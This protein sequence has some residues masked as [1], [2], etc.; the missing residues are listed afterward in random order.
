[1]EYQSCRKSGLWRFYRIYKGSRWRA[2]LQKSFRTQHPSCDRGERY[3]RGRNAPLR[4]VFKQV[5]LF[6]ACEISKRTVPILPH[7]K[8]VKVQ[9]NI[10]QQIAT[11][12]CSIGLVDPCGHS[13]SRHCCWDI[14]T[15]LPDLHLSQTTNQWDVS[16]TRLP[17]ICQSANN[18]VLRFVF[19]QLIFFKEYLK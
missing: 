19:D 18:R 16:E 1:M 2:K 13:N 9:L 15:Q 12:R 7:R 11:G 3:R 6:Y 17:Q 14:A 8:I 10:R 5:L 4:W